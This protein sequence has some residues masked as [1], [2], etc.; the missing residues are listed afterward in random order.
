MQKMQALLLAIAFRLFPS[1]IMGER[2]RKKFITKLSHTS[3]FMREKHKNIH[4]PSV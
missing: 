1:K 4:P 3:D 2:L